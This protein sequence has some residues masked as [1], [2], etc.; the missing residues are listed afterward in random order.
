MSNV[1]IRPLYEFNMKK[2]KRIKK[3]EKV[4]K[5]FISIYCREN[6]LKQGIEVYKNGYC[7][8]CYGLLQYALKKN[9]NCPFDPKPQCKH[10][11][12]HCY[13]KEMRQKIRKVMKFSGI[14]LIKHG[15]IDLILHYFL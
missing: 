1:K 14:Y 11:K 6:H 12:V 15:R 13:S 3:D 4:L 8:E 10:C 5:N 2:S 9:E 7:K